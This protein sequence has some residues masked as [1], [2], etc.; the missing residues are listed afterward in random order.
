M[1]LNFNI[2]GQFITRTDD[3]VIVADSLNQVAMVFSFSDDWA[4]INATAIISTGNRTF[5]QIIVDNRIEPENLPALRAGIN[6]ISVFGGN[7]KTANTCTFTVEASGLRTAPPSIPQP[8][9]NQLYDLVQTKQSKVDSNLLVADGNVV[10]AINKHETDKVDKV[11]GKSLV[12][13]TEITKLAGITANATK[14]EIANDKITINGVATNIENTSD[15]SKPVS[16]QQ[17][18]A[19]DLKA[20]KITTYSK[21]ETDGFLDLKATIQN[22]TSADGTIEIAELMPSIAKTSVG[23][24][25]KYTFYAPTAQK[26]VFSRATETAI[27]NGVMVTF[28]TSDII[29]IDSIFIEK[30]SSGTYGT[31]KYYQIATVKTNTQNTVGYSREITATKHP[32]NDEY[33]G[34]GVSVWQSYDLDNLAK[35]ATNTSNITNLSNNKVD[36]DGTKVLSDNNYSTAEQTKLDGISENAKKVADSTTN[37]NILI[38]DDETQVYDDTDVTTDIT[39]LTDNQADFKRYSGFENRTDSTISIDGSGLFT[40]APTSTSFNVYSWTNGKTTLSNTQYQ[41]GLTDQTINYLYLDKDGVLQ[42]STSIWD[43]LNGDIIPVA[44]VVKDGLIYARQDERHGYTR[45]LNWHKSEHLDTGTVY[46]TGLTGTFTNTTLS[47]TQGVIADEDIEYDTTSTKTTATLWYRNA[48]NGMRML[49]NSSTPYATGLTYDNGTGTLATTTNNRF[50][51][52]YV[53][54]AADNTEPIYIIVGQNQH[55]TIANARNES[56]PIVNLSTAEWKLLYRVTFQKTTGGIVFVETS[57]LRTIKTGSPVNPST[58]ISHASTTGRELANSHPATA[59]SYEATTVQG[60]L[61]TNTTAI[62]NKQ[63]KL[64]TTTLTIDTPFPAGDPTA[65]TGTGIITLNSHGLANL[66]FVEITEGTGTSPTIT[67]INTLTTDTRFLVANKKFAYIILIDTNTFRLATTRANAIAGTSTAITN[68][69]T[70]GWKIRTAGAV[71]PIIDFAGTRITSYSFVGEYYLDSTAGGAANVQLACLTSANAFVQWESFRYTTL[72][73][74]AQSALIIPTIA[75]ASFSFNIGTINVNF[76][77]DFNNVCYGV[78]SHKQNNF[79][80]FGTPVNVAISAIGLDAQTIKKISFGTDGG[81]G[82]LINL[83][84]SKIVERGF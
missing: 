71:Q 64:I 10:N 56:L 25:V 57:D 78:A 5:T 65:D 66:A 77:R 24:Y 58:I 17:Q 53:Y 76:D 31:V 62:A 21:T 72:A 18:T 67:G 42:K 81:Q 84:G 61:D 22:L 37:G 43:I 40:L 20:D 82:G 14:T 3:N 45:D 33:A 6:T 75:P 7:F 59:I 28:N 55:T 41:A 30:T 32:T 79:T 2:D 50:V 46:R 12:L 9:Y 83:N 15:L 49:R 47:I 52:S 51:N 36:K 48:T 38:D 13:D 44:T 60:Q 8:A 63:D 34:F 70:T 29:I 69:G 39:T 26:A 74:G 23:G 11:T 80:S 16:T 4:G 35:I 1:E 54:A 73:A 19:L 27:I 68:A